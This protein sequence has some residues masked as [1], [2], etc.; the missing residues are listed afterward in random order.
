VG[1]HVGRRHRTEFNRTEFNRTEFNRTEF[2]RT[3][4]LAAAEPGGDELG[5]RSAAWRPGDRSRARSASP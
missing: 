5:T 3:G 4:V 2:N 1:L